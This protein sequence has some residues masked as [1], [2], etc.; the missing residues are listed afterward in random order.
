[1]KIHGNAFLVTGG[2]GLIGSAICDQLVERGAGRVVVLDN[3]VRGFQQNIREPIEKGNVEFIDG[4]IC[5][6]ALVE[7][8]VDEVDGVFHMAALRIRHAHEEPDLAFAVMFEAPYKLFHLIADRPGMRL[9]AASS[10]S[11][12]GQADEFPT[13]EM[14]HPYNDDTV[15][16]AAKLAAEGVMRSLHARKGLSYATMRFFNVYG[17]RMDIHGVYTEVMVRWM[18][19]IDEGLAPV[20]HGDGSAAFDFT[21]V[22]DVARACVLAME[23]DRALG[24]YNIGTGISTT[25]KEIAEE[26]VRVMG[27]NVVP[28]MVDVPN[29]GGVTHRQAS[30]EKAKTDFGFEPQADLG[31][32][33]TKLVEWWRANRHQIPN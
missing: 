25:L 16:G 30:I 14:H 10:S 24:A 17:P 28:E 15:Y 23:E 13:D 31:T 7:R 27:K 11:V 32:G 22:D 2:A 12:Y 9:I 33:L 19:R 26:L 4:D 3:L 1:M 5:D 8:L 21:F 6:S 18:Q 29:A 20:I